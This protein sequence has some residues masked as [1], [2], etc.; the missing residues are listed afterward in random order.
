MREPLE[1]AGEL[2]PER[3]GLGGLPL[4]ELHAVAEGEARKEVHAVNVHR[5]GETARSEERAEPVHVAV[6]GISVEGHA[7][8]VAGE[9]LAA[10]RRPQRGQRPPQRAARPLVVRVGPEQRGEPVA[11]LGVPGHGEVRQ[12]R[13]R[14][15]RVG[16]DRP[17][18]AL[19]TRRAEEKHAQAR[20]GRHARRLAAGA[21]RRKRPAVTIFGRRAETIRSRRVRSEAMI[22]ASSFSR[23]E[24]LGGMAY[25]ALVLTSRAAR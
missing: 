14:L 13:D 25:N 19:D 9:V 4:V 10:E 1:G 20:L 15:A 12:E 23:T 7:Q 22:P 17:S 18:V 11:P 5:L 3:V 8:P 21:L 24:P 16:L 2:L 6:E